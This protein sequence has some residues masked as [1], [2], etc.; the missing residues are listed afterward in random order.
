MTTSNL[1]PINLVS[2]IKYIGMMQNIVSQCT[3]SWNRVNHKPSM[4]IKAKVLRKAK[5]GKVWS[6]KGRPTKGHPPNKLQANP[7]P[8]KTYLH[9]WK[10]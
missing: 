1:H 8:W 10:P 4:P 9:N 5:K 3:Q 7:T 6:T 2:I